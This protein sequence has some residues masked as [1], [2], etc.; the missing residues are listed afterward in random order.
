MPQILLCLRDECGPNSRCILEVTT[1]H[2][3]VMLL[4]L[5]TSRWSQFNLHRGAIDFPSWSHNGRF[6]YFGDFDSPVG[7]FQEVGTPGTIAFR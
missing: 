6:I 2:D 1:D 5:Q 4:D 7:G 3:D